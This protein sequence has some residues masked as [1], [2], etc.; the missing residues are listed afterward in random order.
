[1][2]P[3]EFWSE[4]FEEPETT[5]EREQREARVERYE[6]AKDIFVAALRE[7]VRVANEDDPTA[8]LSDWAV[9]THILT[10]D[11]ERAN[12]SAMSMHVP[13]DQPLIVTTG[14]ITRAAHVLARQ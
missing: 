4:D 13:S 6:E 14:L 2:I 11:M 7:F 3:E 10:H 12:I 5:E 1:M 9:V 8:Y